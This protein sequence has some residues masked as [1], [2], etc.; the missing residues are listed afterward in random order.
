MGPQGPQGEPGVVDYAEVD[1]IIHSYRFGRYA[2]YMAAASALDIDLPQER[3]HRLS[4]TGAR[5]GGVSTGVGIGYAW[6]DKGGTALKVGY[7]RAGSESMVKLG[8]SFEF[9]DERGQVAVYEAPK[10]DNYDMLLARVNEL[11]QRLAAI[12][13]DDE[14]A[15]Y[16]AQRIEAHEVVS[17]AEHSD[18]ATRLDELEQQR[19]RDA[20]RAAR[21]AREQAEY[22]AEQRQFAQE[23]LTDLEKYK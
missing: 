8:V 22:E 7:A 10:N 3:G 2:D 12:P 11:E 14:V 20:A 23:A 16:A 15:V 21:I 19:K 5:I 13:Q 18:L 4:V 1:R 17:G 9:G 6:M